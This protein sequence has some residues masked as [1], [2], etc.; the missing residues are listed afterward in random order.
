M[1]LFSRSTACSHRSAISLYLYLVCLLPQISWSLLSPQSHLR[2]RACQLPPYF[3]ASLRTPWCPLRPSHQLCHLV[4]KLFLILSSWACTFWNPSSRLSQICLQ[5]GRLEQDVEL[6][7]RMPWVG[8]ASCIAFLPSKHLSWSFDNARE[9]CGTRIRGTRRISFDL[10]WSGQWL[11]RWLSSWIQ[12]RLHLPSFL[13][14]LTPSYEHRTRLHLL[15]PI[16]S[17]HAWM[18]SILSKFAARFSTRSLTLWHRSNGSDG[19]LL[20]SSLSHA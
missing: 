13:R 18:T 7:R 6:T 3:S 1:A 5:T 20:R 4:S 19:S 8:Q 16:S 10:A 15:W 17:L 12:R 14:F 11:C 9:R 2:G